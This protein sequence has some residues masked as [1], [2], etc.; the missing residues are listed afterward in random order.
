MKFHTDDH[1]VLGGNH[2]LEG[3]PCQDHALSGLMGDSA[4][5]VLADGCSTGE[6]TDIGA[7]ITTTA[8]RTAL[9]NF[10]AS[11]EDRLR[12]QE[13]DLQ[14]RVMLSSIRET[15]GLTYK[16]MQATCLWA[17]LSPKGGLVHLRG[18]GILALAYAGNA[19]VFRK[20]E[21]QDNAPLYP[22]YAE[23]GYAGFKKHHGGDE[24][25]SLLEESAMFA[26]GEWAMLE[27]AQHSVAAGIRGIT[28]E[29]SAKDAREL[30]YVALMSDGAAQVDN[31]GWT[32]VALELVSFK[33][34]EGAFA[35]RR[36]IRF[37]KDARKKGD[38]P[39][40]DMSLAVIRIDNSKENTDV[41]QHA[42]GG[43]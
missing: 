29:R 32:E 12:A 10:R 16:D 21:W 14:Q 1:F 13:I 4:Y 8:A 25:L 36:L 18:D 6:L 40:D 42:Q 39:L 7:R 41:G 43:A 31:I 28:V 37:L 34:S 23:D 22:I 19:Y 33:N 26:D 30:E 24:A 2:A 15:L 5:A 38:G 20:F 17:Y 3:K 9:R 11:G 27:Q 35:K